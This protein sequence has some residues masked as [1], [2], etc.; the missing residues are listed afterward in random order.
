M[1]EQN[2]EDQLKALR[3][4]LERSHEE[5]AALAGRVERLVDWTAAN[6]SV[7]RTRSPA[8]HPDGEKRASAWSSLRHGLSEAGVLGKDIGRGV[9]TEIERHPVLGGIAAFGLGFGLAKLLFKDGRS[10]PRR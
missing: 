7:V 9:A 3:R 2:Q 1:N 10:N 6:S 4:G 8:G 5:I